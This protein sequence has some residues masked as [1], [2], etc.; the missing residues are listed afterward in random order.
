MGPVSLGHRGTLWPPETS[1]CSFQI[2][3]EA[4]ES[5]RASAEIHLEQMINSLQGDPKRDRGSAQIIGSCAEALE[6]QRRQRKFIRKK[7]KILRGALG[8][9]GRGQCP[10]HWGVARKPWKALGNQRKFI[11]K[12]V[13]I[14]RRALGRTGGGSAQITRELRGSLGNP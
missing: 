14:L 8:K 1:R 4:C 2:K 13:K 10:N 3:Q 11:R 5:L 6:S 9:D 7:V 12:K